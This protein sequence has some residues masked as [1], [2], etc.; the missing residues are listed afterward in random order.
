VD[1]RQLEPVL[2]ELVA[3]ATA[4]WPD[5]EVPPDRFIAYLTARLP[6]EQEL[7]AALRRVRTADLYLTC[8]CV[9]GI[10]SALAEF[11]RRFQQVVDS[12]LMRFAERGV[13]VDDVKQ[14]LLER[15]LLPRAGQPARIAQY[16][17]YG[18]L[19]G[20]LTV[21]ATQEAL[22]LSQKGKKEAP[23][24]R[25]EAIAAQVAAADDPE[26]NVLKERYREQFKTAFQGAISALGDRERTLL[27]YYFVSELSTREI[28][29]LTGVDHS[30]AARRLAQIRSALLA[31]TRRSL[32]AQLRIGR[33]EFDS[34]ARMVESQLDLSIERVLK[35]D[36]T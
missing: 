19:D 6:A 25:P 29:V 34:I 31:A 12:A 8:S 36:S 14:Q 32:M 15:L 1:D 24:F 5:F 7:L 10:E 26:L 27:R 4:A 30:T 9:D 33:S 13:S 21:A 23:C 16:A 3:A 22:K 18:S 28:G 17:G 35:V 20:Y 11:N 2:E